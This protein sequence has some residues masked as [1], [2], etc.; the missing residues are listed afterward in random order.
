MK[1]LY[2]K[3]YG[4]VQGVFFRNFVQK[5][6]RARGITGYA[7]NLPEGAVEVVAQG[8]EEKL[9]EFLGRISSGPEQAEVESVDASWGPAGDETFSDFSI[10]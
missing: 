3:I 6:A 1:E 2:C 10:L 5:E 9:K 4:D 7:K 8:A